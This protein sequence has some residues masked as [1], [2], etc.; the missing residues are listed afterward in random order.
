MSN[1]NTN[2][3]PSTSS[4]R[5]LRNG[6][7][8]S[9]FLLGMGPMP[10]P[11]PEDIAVAA[12]YSAM[13]GT[14]QSQGSI[15]SYSQDPDSGSQQSTSVGYG[16]Q[17]ASQV[18]EA[19]ASQDQTGKK[20]MGLASHEGKLGW[21]YVDES[22]K[23]AR[24]RLETHQDV[25]AAFDAIIARKRAARSKP[26]TMEISNLDFDPKGTESGKKKEGSKPT[27]MTE[28]AYGEELRTVQNKLACTIHGKDK[29]RWCYID[30]SKPNEHIPLDLETVQL[31]ARKIHDGEVPSSCA[32][33]P[34]VLTLDKLRNKANE[35]TTRARHAAA[36]V[37]PVAPPPM[38]FHF[39]E[40]LDNVPH[41]LPHVRGSK[42]LAP[43]HN[44]QVDDLEEEEEPV[45]IVEVL[46]ALDVKQPLANYPTY[47]Q[48]L[49][50]HGIYYAR[51]ALDFDTEFYAEE[52]GMPKGLIVSFLRKA[53]A[54][55]LDSFRAG[56]TTHGEKENIERTPKRRRVSA[57]GKGR[58]HTRTPTASPRS[59]RSY[60]TSVK[61]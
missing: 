6:T 31:W 18:Q 25:D 38:H 41:H 51:N 39:G 9:R 16:S 56:I 22:Q 58:A 1:Q 48:A 4:N 49:A 13:D 45:P 12:M 24:R 11:R 27:K 3:A 37:Q 26:I 32:V 46:Q 21:K 33:L 14:Q 5:S 28:C 19:S 15:A 23:T 8:I 30:P 35:R 34:N 55:V 52:V 36:K 10:P 7:S 17:S 42:R 61:I 44:F 53:R 40:A 54:L 57:K 43:D 60:T 59:I 50:R 29:D 20:C 47:E 2:F